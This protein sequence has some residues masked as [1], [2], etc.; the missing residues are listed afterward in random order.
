MSIAFRDLLRE[1]IS[2]KKFQGQECQDSVSHCK[3]SGSRHIHVLTNCAAKHALSGVLNSVNSSWTRKAKGLCCWV[4]LWVL[5]PITD[6]KWNFSPNLRHLLWAVVWAGLVESRR[7]SLCLAVRPQADPIFRFLSL[8]PSCLCSAPEGKSC[9]GFVRNLHSE[10]LVWAG[11]SGS[12][13]K[14]AEVTQLE[15]FALHSFINHTGRSPLLLCTAITH[16]LQVLCSGAAA[17]LSTSS[18]F[19]YNTAINQI[20]SIYF[21]HYKYW[22]TFSAQRKLAPLPLDFD[23]ELFVGSKW[24]HTSHQKYLSV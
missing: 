22:L 13:A 7:N 5:L 16:F 10:I 17:V 8:C 1:L 3:L 2:K 14:P 20:N 15:H 11:G 9:C 21:S 6:Q 12:R 4:L 23:L 24:M 19:Y 18:W